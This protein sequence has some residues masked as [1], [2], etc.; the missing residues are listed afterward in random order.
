MAEYDGVS[1]IFRKG[2]DV[3]PDKHKAVSRTD[4]EKRRREQGETK[5]EPHDTV[6][7]HAEDDAPAD[8]AVEPALQQDQPEEEEGF[9]ISA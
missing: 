3:R 2:P 5:D 4:R 1:R 6:E 7:L 8:E 9:D